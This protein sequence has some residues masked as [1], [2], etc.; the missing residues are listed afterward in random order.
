M[1]SGVG[2][3]THRL[4]Q[5]VLDGG[6]VTVGMADLRGFFTQPSRKRVFAV[7]FGLRYPDREIDLLP[8]DE[9]LQT[10]L[11][12]IA[13]QAKHIYFAIG[14]F[15]QETDPETICCRIN[16][17]EPTFGRMKNPL[18]QKAVAVLAGLGWI[19][20]SSLLV[21]P[22]HG[23][24]LRIGTLFTDTPLAPDE[25]YKANHCGICQIC[26]DVCP[27]QAVSGDELWFAS[28]LGYR[29]DPETCQAHLCRN[30][31]KIHRQEFCGLCLKECPFGKGTA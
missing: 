28:L 5:L 7:A 9:A 13:E 26:G 21:H 8:S 4:K 20:K 2:R 16:E 6:A 10:A 22:V 3:R 1:D 11:R 14:A 25:P 30:E 24:R 15:I 18:S 12:D 19:G 31:S 27:V 17:V 29:I 23:P